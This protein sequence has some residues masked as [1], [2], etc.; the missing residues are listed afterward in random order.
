MKIYQGDRTID[1]V[2][3]EVDGAELPPHREVHQFSDAAF[4]WGYEG[5][6]ATQLA[7]ALIY[8]HSG[9]A[10]LAQ[11]MAAPFM[12]LVTA[13][14]GNDWELTSQDIEL[15]LTQLAA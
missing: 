12:A 13:N 10:G 6:A 3:V 5:A 15:A 9:D 14:F 7:L 11:R 2:V 8:D 1:G 4:E